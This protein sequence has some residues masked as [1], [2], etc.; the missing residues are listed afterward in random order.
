MAYIKINKQN[1]YHNLNKLALKAGSIEKIAVVLKDNA[2][3]HG[4]QHIA[5]LCSQHGVTQAVVVHDSEVSKIKQYFEHILVL[6]GTPIAADNISYAIGDM[7]TLFS[8]ASDVSIELKID[9]GMHR[10]GISMHQLDEALRF[11]KSAN[12]NL[13]GIMTH[14]KSAD[15]MSSELYWQQKNFD[16]VKKKVKLANFENIRFHSHNS[17]ALIRSQSFDDDIAR[18]GIAI[19]GYSELPSSYNNLQLKPVLS[20]WAK[21]VSTKVLPK[22]SKIGYGG[23]YTVKDD[24][25]ISTYDLGYGDGWLRGDCKN[26]YRTPDDMPI[27][28]KVSMD[29]ISLESKEDEICIMS[30]AQAVARHFDTICYEIT[31]SLSKDLE[32]IIV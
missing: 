27:L 16:T 25:T 5:E 31:T 22:G 6:D 20:L 14:F 18:C 9:T 12:L 15:I 19:Y 32:K 26:P 7:Q 17:A 13:T 10:N 29:F 8:L 28:G 30:D 1:L 3:G 11:I 2:Y 4:I 21:R 24:T 23:C